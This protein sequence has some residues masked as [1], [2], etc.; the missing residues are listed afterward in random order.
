M[1][2]WWGFPWGFL[3]TPV[4][5]GRNLSAMV[6]APSTGPSPE[7]VEVAR[8]ALAREQG[9]AAGGVNAPAKTGHVAVAVAVNVNDNVNDNDNDNVSDNLIALLLRAQVLEDRPRHLQVRL[10]VDLAEGLG[11]GR[12]VPSLHRR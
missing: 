4:Q 6:A 1:A 5:I 12:G 11:E 2:G 3:F 7:L 8:Q 9:A 10:V